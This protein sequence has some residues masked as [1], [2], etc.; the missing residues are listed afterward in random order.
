MNAAWAHLVLN[1]VPILGVAF[2]LPLLA[3][4]LFRRNETLLRAGWVALVV[5]AL[6]AG[7]V[8]LAGEGAE[9]IV[10]DLPGVS[11]D[12]IE[13][14][15]EI[16]LFALIGAVTLGVV[17]LAARVLSRRGPAPEWL[18]IGSLVLA[19]VVAGIMTATA[20]K[21]GRIRH[22]EAHDGIAAD[23]AE[24]ETEEEGGGGRGRGR[25]GRH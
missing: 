4:A 15:E 10:E 25:R 23:D 18:R 11:H 5:V 17:S 20:D 19:L 9:E 2:A 1:H 16:A 21:G 3:V 13:A 7:P 14:H 8:Y 6:V 22:P 12:A 24:D